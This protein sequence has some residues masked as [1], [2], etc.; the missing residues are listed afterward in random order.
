MDPCFVRKIRDLSR[1]YV[2]AT[3]LIRSV[4]NLPAALPKMLNSVK[5]NLN[6]VLVFDGF[7]NAGTPKLIAYLGFGVPKSVR[8]LEIRTSRRADGRRL[9]IDNSYGT[10]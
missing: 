4:T 2:H 1:V 7:C 8:A 3:Q 5:F 6:L 9:N 10:V